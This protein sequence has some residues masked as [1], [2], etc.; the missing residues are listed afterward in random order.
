MAISIKAPGV[1]KAEP[2]DATKTFT[3][4]DPGVYKVKTTEVSIHKTSEGKES[5]QVNFDTVEPNAGPGVIYLG[6]DFSKEAN[7]RKVLT[8]LISHGGKPD[9]IAAMGD[10][11]ELV[12]AFFVGRSA[13][14]N[15]RLVDDLDAKGR[16]RL[17]DKEFVRPEDYEVLRARYAANGP[18]RSASASPAP[19]AAPK[20]APP[21]SAASLFE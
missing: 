20:A 15:V 14:V 16:K 19:T 5:L 2:W 21:A 7:K 9:R 6:L 18:A 10:E 4:L 3:D 12:D 8:A 11:L 1:A 13:F 17:N